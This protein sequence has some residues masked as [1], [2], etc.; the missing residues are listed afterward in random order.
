[1]PSFWCWCF[2]LC[3]HVNTQVANALLIVPPT[4]HQ[5]VSEE[6]AMYITEL[7]A[8]PSMSATQVTFSVYSV[9]WQQTG[10]DLHAIL[11]R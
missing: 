11:Y 3:S 8:I 9:G 4:A 10:M 1:M 5:T 7:H 6:L 2:D